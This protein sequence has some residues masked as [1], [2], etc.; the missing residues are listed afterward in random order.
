VNLTNSTLSGNSANAGA[1]G[2]ENSG[3]ISL[4]NTIVANGGN[5]GGSLPTDNGNNFA[6]DDTC[7]SGF[8]DI[9]PGVDFDT[10]LAENGGPTQTHALLPG[11]V[12]IDAAGDCGLDT[13]QRDFLRWDGACDSGSFE[14]GAMPADADQDGVL[15]VEDTC[16]DTTIPE[17]VPTNHLRVNRWAL[18]DE[19]GIFDTTSPP[20]GGGGPDFDFTVEDTRGCSCEQII[21]A[22]GLG[23]GHTKFGCSTGVMLQW[24]AQGGG[25][26]LRHHDAEAERL[27][28]GAIQKLVEGS[29]EPS[30]S[31]NGIPGDARS[32]RQPLIRHRAGRN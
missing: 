2:I 3:T 4:A 20:G 26:D 19:D 28:P 27:P 13:D 29:D 6:D 12:A 25:H 15:D 30:T 5:C 14:Y 24:I 18:V 16:L 10:N 32:A 23:R 9:I 21:E 8:A 31:V 1:G 17:S 11:S 7:G 22:M